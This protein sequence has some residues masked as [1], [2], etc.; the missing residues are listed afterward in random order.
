MAT[1]VTTAAT[2]SYLKQVRR[3]SLR[4][5]TEA[6]THGA[7]LRWTGR[8][9]AQRPQSRRTSGARDDRC[10]VGVADARVA[11]VAGPEHLP[12]KFAR[13]QDCFSQQPHVG[14][15]TG[16]KRDEVVVGQALASDQNEMIRLTMTKK[17]SQ[18]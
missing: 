11:R 16:S 8:V 10:Q 1:E 17:K 15:V 13:G 9:V 7:G 6:I 2:H 3:A 14:L 5:A 12:G 4:R 18:W